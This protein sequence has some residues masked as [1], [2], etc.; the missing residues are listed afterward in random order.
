MEK[1]TEN[2]YWIGSNDRDLDL[3]ESQY[4]VLKGMSYNSYLIDDEKIAILDTVN[5][6]GEKDW[7]ENLKL[8]LNNRNPDYLII[9]HLEPDHSS[10]IGWIMNEYPN[11]KLI[12][13]S[14]TFSMLPQFCSI[15]RLEERKIEVKEGDTFKIGSHELKFFMAPMVHWPEVMVSYESKEKI[16]FSADAFGKFGCRDIEEEW[17]DEA[18]RFFI[19]IVGKYGIQVQGLLK[20]ALT[21]DINTICSLHGPVLTGDLSKYIEKYDKWSKYESEESGILV[22]CASIHGNTKK[23]ADDFVNKLKL[24]NTKIEYYDLTRCDMSNAIAKAYQYDRIVLFASTYN[25]GVFP[26]MEMFLRLLKD[27]NFQ[28]RKVA[29]VE[30]GSWAPSAAKTMKNIID[31]MK[32]IDIIEPIVT[33]I[34][35]LDENSSNQLD[36]L[37]A[38]LIK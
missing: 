14:K 6:R 29:L 32:N 15:D 30:N 1:I 22:L 12:G 27:K 16:L 37:A 10:L 35:T 7:K 20:K 17:T 36:E 13:N 11:L 25:M 38:N 33:I 24:S 21:L 31:E 18:R 19:N 28:N 9:H 3:F 26:P 2:I 34:T 23:V 8:A 5:P 4:K